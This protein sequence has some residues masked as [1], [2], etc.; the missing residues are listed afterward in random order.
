M[1]EALVQFEKM[2][3]DVERLL[4]HHP[5]FYNPLP[6]KPANDEGPLLRS[7]IVLTY[8][9]WEFYFEE[10]LIEVATAF[11]EHPIDYLPETLRKWVGAQK[12]T[13]SDPWALAG[14]GWRK[15]LVNAVTIYT[16]GVENDPTS[17]GI[18]T[19]NSWNVEDVHR[20]VL[21]VSI[22]RQIRWGHAKNEYVRETLDELVRLRG[23]IAHGKGPTEPL[24]L[25]HVKTWIKFAERLVRQ[26]DTRLFKWV[27]KHFDGLAGV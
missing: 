14:D 24:H 2:L 12:V 25:S 9:A 3:S 1:S 4:A 8:A 11:S 18:N 13:T 19:A 23:D 10:S 5:N 22:L 26:Y 6:G 27:D 16:R 15:A 7:C 21:G 17:F 20:K